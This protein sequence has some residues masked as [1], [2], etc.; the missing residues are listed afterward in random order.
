M[1]VE[2]I[3]VFFGLVLCPISYIFPDVLCTVCYQFDRFFR[4]I[5]ISRGIAV[6]GG[7]YNLKRRKQRT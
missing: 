2:F 4:R 6:S 5:A 3:R 1:T 7:R